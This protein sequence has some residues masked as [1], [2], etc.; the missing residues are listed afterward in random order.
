MTDDR[1]FPVLG[2]KP[3][4]TVPW[5]FIQAHARQAERNHSQTLK[6]LAERGGLS[7]GEIRL[8]IE[9]RGLD[10][11][12]HPGAEGVVR[13]AVEVWRQEVEA[14]DASATAEARRRLL[15][16]D[17]PFMPQDK[18]LVIGIDMASGPDREGATVPPAAH[19]IEQC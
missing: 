4:A 18:P 17:A 16:C 7:W 13:A 12:L 9:A 8:A 1:E 11:R 6:R 19:R 5:A 3:A 14:M 10:F 15:V 2:S